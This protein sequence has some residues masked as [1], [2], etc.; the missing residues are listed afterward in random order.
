MH[1]RPGVG[2]EQCV[3]RVF[4]DPDAVVPEPPADA[5]GRLQRR[6]PPRPRP[7]LTVAAEVVE[8]AQQRDQRIIGSL[9]GKVVDVAS[10]EVRPIP[11]ATSGCGTRPRAAAARAARRSR[12][13][14]PALPRPNGPP[15]I[16][17]RDR[18]PAGEGDRYSRAVPSV[19]RPGVERE[20]SHLERAV[21]G[22][23]RVSVIERAAA[24]RYQ[25]PGQS[26][27][28]DF[29]VVVVA[30]AFGQFD[31][32]LAA[33]ANFR[34]ANRQ[35]QG[36]RQGLRGR[37]SPAL[38]EGTLRYECAVL[39]DRSCPA[40]RLSSSRPRGSAPAASCSSRS[41]LV[42][43]CGSEALNRLAVVRGDCRAKR[44]RGSHR[45]V[46]STR[47]ALE[48]D[49]R[50]SW[51]RWWSLGPPTEPWGAMPISGRLL[52]PWRK[53]SGLTNARLYGYRAY[54]LEAILVP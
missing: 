41:L 24:H 13:P 21:Q 5:H 18:A 3:V 49:G 46:G 28:P 38:R 7:E 26:Q 36:R 51:G 17:T 33:V 8:L 32:K 37:Q 29:H 2:D 23:S 45:L 30:Q 52:R 54:R 42:A 10:G 34:S 15:K 40:R 16:A 14:A 27:S 1:R 4:R 53:P 20:Q 48:G 9:D 31:E 44:P 6:E 11:N 43:R 47:R 35:P 19:S 39:A 50:D 12:G 22:I 25:M